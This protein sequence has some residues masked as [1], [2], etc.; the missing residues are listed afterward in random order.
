MRNMYCILTLATAL[1]PF[2]ALQAAPADLPE[3]GQSACWN[4][5]GTPILCSATGQDGD[6]KAGVA[7]PVP[8][9]VVGTGAEADCI[10]DRLT[11]LMWL[12]QGNGYYTYDQ[13]AAFGYAID[14]TTCGHN[15]W[16]LP[17]IVEL[18]SLVN[19][20][21]S[22][23]A[24]YLNAQGFMNIT[25]PNPHQSGS[26]SE[27]CWSST[28]HASEPNKAWVVNMHTGS[29]TYEIKLPALTPPC[30]LPVRGGH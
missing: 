7:W 8:R 11:G 1:I 21:Y 3:T 2:T 4:A 16:R 29:V 9:F 19:S 6:L 25:D 17:N 23:P 22:Y 20:A 18:E 28:S 5:T 10:T 24:D 26:A 15:D 30:I 13:M 14:L 12:R 27:S